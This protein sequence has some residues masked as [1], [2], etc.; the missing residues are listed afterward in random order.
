MFRSHHRPGGTTRKM[1]TR[2]K[3]RKMVRLRRSPTGTRLR[4]VACRATKETN[5]RK[6]TEIRNR[7]ATQTRGA[8]AA[9]LRR[10]ASRRTTS[11]QTRQVNLQ[12]CRIQKTQR[13]GKVRVA[14]T[15]RNLR[16][17]ASRQTI[18][19]RLAEQAKLVKK[20]RTEVA[21]SLLNLVKP[22]SRSLGAG[23]RAVSQQSRTAVT[24]R[25][26]TAAQARDRL[27]IPQGRDQTES[28][29]R[30]MVRRAE[31]AEILKTSRLVADR[32]SPLEMTKGSGAMVRRIRRRV[33]HQLTSHR[34]GNEQVRKGRMTVT[35]AKHP[36]MKTDQKTARKVRKPAVI[37]NWMTR[38]AGNLQVAM[39]LAKQESPA[40][41]IQTAVNQARARP[42]TDRVR[43]RAGKLGKVPA[44]SRAEVRTLVGSPWRV[45]TTMQTL[46]TRFSDRTPVPIRLIQVWRKRT[47]QI[48]TTS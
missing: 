26:T 13:P 37:R 48:S 1:E 10:L 14:V 3:S 16:R 39:R 24:R 8:I 20:M 30:K 17:T 32:P 46:M 42:V 28:H 38:R 23:A 31:L 11:R 21:T 25:V 15:I 9:I 12:G 36:A 47:R 7:R 41:G 18:L 34:P 44:Q 45:P 29:R 6:T 27:P 33:S 22:A 35:L 4:K 40:E 19:R 5:R 43:S 2:V